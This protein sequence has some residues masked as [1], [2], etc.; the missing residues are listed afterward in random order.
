FIRTHLQ[1]AEAG[2]LRTRTP[3][4]RPHA[5][6]TRSLAA[7]VSSLRWLAHRAGLPA[8]PPYRDDDQLHPV[9][10]QVLTAVRRS[11]HLLMSLQDFYATRA[12][13][14]L[15]IVWTTGTPI[16]QLPH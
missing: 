3:Q 9:S 1:A 10:A 14:V 16:G 13:A 7:R 5:E 6:S 11:M 4:H 15:A 12:A 8:P 2:T